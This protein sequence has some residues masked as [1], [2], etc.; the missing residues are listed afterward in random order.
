MLTIFGGRVNDLKTI[1]TEERI[2]E[3]WQSRILS[4]KGLTMMAFNTTVIPVEYMT[5]SKKKELAKSE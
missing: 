5:E 1:L 4:R 3:G 2:P